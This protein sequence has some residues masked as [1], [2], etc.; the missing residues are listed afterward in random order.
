MEQWLQVLNMISQKIGKPSFETWFKNTT[1]EIK[2]DVVIVKA[3][4]EFQLNWLE[5]RYSKLI[6][7]VVEK[8]LGKTMK[9]A[10]SC[11]DNVDLKR[12]PS[13]GRSSY[14]AYDELRGLLIAQEERI[15]LLEKRID[16]LEKLK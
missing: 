8:V 7:D 15:K 11:P 13:A 12:Q 14:S 16:L 1:A 3:Q 5:E 9:I 2:G 4:N 10:F 6:L